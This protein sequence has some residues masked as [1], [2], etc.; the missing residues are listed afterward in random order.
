MIIAEIQ[1][2][3]K[4]LNGVT[5]DIK[6]EDHL[7]FNIGGK[8]F[9]VTSPDS[10]PVTASFKVS[11]EDFEEISSR[12]GFMPAPYLARYKWVFVNDIKRMSKKEWEQMISTSYQLIAKKL[13][14]KIKKEIGI[15]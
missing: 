15:I 4:K 2:I 11:D 8:M 6:W 10:V 5:Q 9:L 12:N 13:P 1:A 7:C 14:P 3:C